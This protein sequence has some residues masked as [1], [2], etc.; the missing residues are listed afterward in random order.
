[1][2]ENPQHKRNTNGDLPG[3]LIF[4]LDTLI[5]GN[6]KMRKELCY[7]TRITILMKLKR[8]AGLLWRY[9]L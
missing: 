6:Y 4:N 5:F 9:S 1:M 7:L 8:T 3:H 2:K